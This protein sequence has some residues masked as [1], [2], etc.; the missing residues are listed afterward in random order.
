MS[1]SELDQKNGF[2]V[3]LWEWVSVYVY[4]WRPKRSSDTVG[5]QGAVIDCPVKTYVQDSAVY[6][7]RGHVAYRAVPVRDRPSLWDH[8]FTLVH[9]HTGDQP[10]T[11]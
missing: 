11:C 3:G 6:K 9:Y 8:H 10:P 2:A 4:V 5:V 1:E 7:S